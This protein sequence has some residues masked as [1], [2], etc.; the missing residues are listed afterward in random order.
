M[1]LATKHHITQSILKVAVFL[2]YVPLFA[3]AITVIVEQEHLTMI[4][5][6]VV[7][8]YRESPQLMIVVYTHEPTAQYVAFL[9]AIYSI[10]RVLT[11]WHKCIPKTLKSTICR[12]LHHTILSR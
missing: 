4:L 3:L 7:G 12:H 9:I 1:K 5:K 8:I 11:T 10:G 6:E 2:P